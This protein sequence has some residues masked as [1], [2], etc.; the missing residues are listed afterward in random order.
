MSLKASEIQKDER[1]RQRWRE[2][3]RDIK[4]KEEHTI[5]S[6]GLRDK[7]TVREEEKTERKRERG[8]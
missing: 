1:H 7:K 3:E 6:E 4:K 2:R 8:R 5:E